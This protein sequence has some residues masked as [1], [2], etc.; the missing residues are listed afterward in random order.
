MIRKFFASV[1]IFKV[2]FLTDILY[3]FSTTGK[4]S[5][6]LFFLEKNKNKI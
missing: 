4:I 3:N 5:N 2:N 6:E 1:V